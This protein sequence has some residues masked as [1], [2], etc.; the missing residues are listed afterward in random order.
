MRS[1][2]CSTLRGPPRLVAHDSAQKRRSPS[3]SVWRACAVD[4]SIAHVACRCAA[5][6][7]ISPSPASRTKSSSSPSSVVQRAGYAAVVEARRADQL[8]RHLALHALDG[9][10]EQVVGVVVGRR[11]RVATA[12]PRRASRR[13]SARRAR[14]ASPSASSRSSR[15]RWCRARSAARR[16]PRRRRGRAGTRRRCDRAGHRRR[17]RRRS[18]A[19]TATRPSRPA[20]PARRVWQSDRNA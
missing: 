8:D 10:Y 20:R 16:A 11:T 18:A 13:S 1:W 6:S 7:P 4:P 19:G 15:A 3:R 2:A 17:S 12:R 5:A 9:A 14:R